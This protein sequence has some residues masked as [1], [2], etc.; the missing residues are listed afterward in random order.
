MTQK[1][2][3]ITRLGRWFARLRGGETRS[4]QVSSEEVRQAEGT[5][6]IQDEDEDSRLLKSYFS[7]CY[8]S[9]IRYIVLI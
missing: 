4:Q 2:A 3:E 9:F 5:G 8:S 1:S 7:F 6:M